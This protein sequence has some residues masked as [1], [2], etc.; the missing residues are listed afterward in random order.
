M[1]DEGGLPRPRLGNA[2]ERMAAVLIRGWVEA[3]ATHRKGEEV[4]R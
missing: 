3:R 4:R 1:S 2:E